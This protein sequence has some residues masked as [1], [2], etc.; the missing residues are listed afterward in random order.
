MEYIY[1]IQR[2]SGPCKVGISKNVKSRFAQLKTSSHEPLSI[3]YWAK[4]DSE[5][6]FWFENQILDS[7]SSRMNGEWFDVEPREAIDAIKNA[8]EYAQIHIDEF[9]EAPKRSRVVTEKVEPTVVRLP[10][11][12]I[13]K[14]D[15]T[16]VKMG[17]SRAALLRVICYQY[18][19]KA[20]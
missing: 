8:A 3:E 6:A 11:S 13:E 5:T 4:I 16:A 17:L 19:D 9:Y 18:F 1:V 14:L 10:V 7:L 20:A 2:Q 12:L 15:S